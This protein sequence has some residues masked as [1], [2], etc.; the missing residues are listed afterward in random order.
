MDNIK[1][2]PTANGPCSVNVSNEEYRERY[3]DSTLD[4][5]LDEYVLVTEDKQSSPTATNG[6]WSHGINIMKSYLVLADMKDAVATGNGDYLTTLRKQLLMHFSST[7]GF[8]EYAIEMFINILQ[9]HV[10]LSESEAH[11][12]KWA[13]TVNWKGG[14]RNNIEIDL[15]QEN[16]NYEVKKLIKS[17][18]AN[19]T[20]KAITRASKASSGVS[21]VVEAF[22]DQ[23]KMP[24]KSSTHKHRSSTE[25]ESIIQRDLRAL[26]PFERDGRSYEAFAGISPD[27]LHAL[28]KTKF[29]QWIDRHKR[30]ILLHYPLDNSDTDIEMVQS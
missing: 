16:R 8:N 9:C 1:D 4:K 28:D 12:C 26:R 23:V 5:F 24:R 10:L 21:K 25:D 15:F 14:T 13:A 17:V 20:H 6:I 29:K 3:L 11:M 7:R 22:E 30:N 27:P 19:K 18:G 2:K